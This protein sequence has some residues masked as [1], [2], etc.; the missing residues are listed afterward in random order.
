MSEQ[1]ELDGI[2]ASKTVRPSSSFQY[3]STRIR[4]D[5]CRGTKFK[6]AKVHNLPAFFFFPSVDLN[7]K[8]AEVHRNVPQ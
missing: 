3:I 4:F 8:C 7:L 6:A 5:S 1:A 2:F